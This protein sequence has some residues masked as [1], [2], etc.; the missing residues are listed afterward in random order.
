MKG[1]QKLCAVVCAI[2]LVISSFA[3]YD[4]LTKGADVNYDSLKWVAVNGAADLAVAAQEDFTFQSVNQL[5]DGRLEIIPQVGEPGGTYPIWPNFSNPTLNGKPMTAIDGAGI[6][7]PL[8]D[9]VKDSYNVYEAA[10]NFNNQFHIIIRYGNVSSSGGG[11]GGNESTGSGEKPSDSGTPQ[12]TKPGASVEGTSTP[13][14]SALPKKAEGLNPQVKTDTASIDNAVLLAWASV[15]ESANPNYDA[16]VYTYNCYVYKDGTLMTKVCNVTNGCILGGL[17]A[18]TYGF[19][20]AA[21]NAMG[22]GP[23]SERASATVT[24]FQLNYTP[25]AEYPGP[26]IPAGFVIVSAD[27]QFQSDTP[28][29]EQINTLHLAWAASNADAKAPSYDLTVTGYNVYVFDA[30]TGKPY[31]KVHVDGIASNTAVL[32]SVSKGKYVAFV[33]AVNANGESGMAAPGLT[34]ASSVEIDGD[35]FDNA[36][37]FDYPDAPALPEGLEI[38]GQSDGLGEGFNVAWAGTA[39]L[40]GIRINIFVDGV[41]VKSGVENGYQETRLAPGTYEVS[42]TAQ[43]ISNNVECV[44]YTKKITIAGSGT[45]VPEEIRDSSYS[46]YEKPEGPSENP[47]TGETV[48]PTTEETEKQPDNPA[49]E[50]T[51]KQPDN[52]ATEETEKQ[53]DNPATE[54]TEGQPDNPTMEETQ[55]QPTNPATEKPTAPSGGETTKQLPDR[56]NNASGN[57]TVGAGGNGN[58]TSSLADNGTVPKAVIKKIAAKKRSA[59]K[60]RVTVKKL[61]GINGYQAKVYASK[62]NAKTNKKAIAKKTFKKN[63]TKLT[64]RGNKL[65]NK[66]KLFVRIR[67]Y[68][69]VSGKKKFGAWSTVKKVKVK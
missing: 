62:K 23:K 63:T 50:E 26:K 57:T 54:E 44:P 31:R 5:G 1:L 61:N 3:G 19:E 51:E 55:A 37:D 35:V 69:I 29:T 8:T 30:D 45:S 38:H 24:G 22:E 7:I 47:E 67:A 66:R 10:D 36:Q 42:V 39:D 48:D 32:K 53:P 11:A 18:G 21:V 27:S 2:A 14:A 41:C 25:K 68:K 4:T 59:K 60:I 16:S 43:Y 34:L 56:Q 58:I 46:A 64:I 28:E 52:P 12:T 20:G 33:T 15:M 9:L 49:T 65:K 13:P 6:F 40:T 17:S